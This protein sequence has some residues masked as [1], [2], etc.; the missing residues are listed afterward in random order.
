MSLLNF[1]STCP[2]QKL[3]KKKHGKIN[4]CSLSIS[5]WGDEI[6]TVSPFPVLIEGPFFLQGGRFICLN[7]F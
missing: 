4:L 7:N 5:L 1:L 6:F 3:N 2:C